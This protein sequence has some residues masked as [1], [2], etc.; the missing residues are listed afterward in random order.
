MKKYIRHEDV[1]RTTTLI[2]VSVIAILILI[3]AGT[4]S[5]LDFPMLPILWITVMV[6]ASAVGHIVWLIVSCFSKRNHFHTVLTLT[7]AGLAGLSFISS[8]AER[9][10][11]EMFSGLGAAIIFLLFTLP[12]AVT[13]IFWLIKGL[14]SLKRRK[15]D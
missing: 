11:G 9:H 6:S 15:A 4:D 12:L 10:S 1:T 13:V 14:V 7:C 2:I 5:L 8:E 3:T